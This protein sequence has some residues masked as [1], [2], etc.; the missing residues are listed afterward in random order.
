M[1]KLRELEPDVGWLDYLEALLCDPLSINLRN[2]IAHGIV[3]QVG[4]AGA[5]LL[6]QAACFLALLRLTEAQPGA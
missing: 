3:E 4:S 6:L 1:S 5:A 2:D